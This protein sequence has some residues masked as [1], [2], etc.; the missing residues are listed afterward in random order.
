MS[1]VAHTQHSRTRRESDA[2]KSRHSVIGHDVVA[3]TEY[4]DGFGPT[5]KEY[6]ARGL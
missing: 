1:A 6:E 3:V 2:A 5:S 4:A